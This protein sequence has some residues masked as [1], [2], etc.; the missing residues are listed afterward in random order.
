MGHENIT[1]ENF[2]NFTNF[3]HYFKDQTLHT[4]NSPVLQVTK[5]PVSSTGPLLSNN[6]RIIFE[7][8]SKNFHLI[9]TATNADKLYTVFS[10]ETV[11]HIAFFA[12]RTVLQHLVSFGYSQDGP[13]NSRSA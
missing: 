10:F 6:P 11:L 5:V 1:V 4:H 13:A 8:L 12:C 3:L 2:I 9:F 7:R